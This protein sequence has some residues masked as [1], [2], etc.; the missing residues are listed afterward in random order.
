M[1]ITISG[2]LPWADVESKIDAY[3][4][5]SSLPKGKEMKKTRRNWLIVMS[6]TMK[7][8]PRVI[9]TDHPTVRARIIVFDHF[10]SFRAKIIS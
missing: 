5:R 4:A 1:L 7:I 6:Q 3:I 8:E 10:F 9:L 2:Q